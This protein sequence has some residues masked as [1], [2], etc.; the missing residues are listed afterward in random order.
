[1]ARPGATPGAASN[2]KFKEMKKSEIILAAIIAASAIMTAGNRHNA[3]GYSDSWCAC[4]DAYGYR[5]D[6][7]DEEATD[8]YLDAWR[9]SVEE[10]NA[11]RGGLGDE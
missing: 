10:E 11:L 8:Y 1:M 3:G 4:C 2:L 7:T 5:Y 6:M 9:G